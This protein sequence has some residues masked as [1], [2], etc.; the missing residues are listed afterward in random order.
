MTSL[1][2]QPSS[3]VFNP[4]IFLSQDRTGRST[5]NYQKNEKIFVQG[6]PAGTVCYIRKGRVKVT[7]LS[8]LGKEAVIGFPARGRFFG[9]GCL[10][11]AELRISTAHAVEECPVTSIVKAT[12]IATLDAEPKFSA[13]FV[14]FLLSQL[15]RKN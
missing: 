6:E 4:R 10:D 9:E 14:A 13:F 8:D 15:Q 3:S 12:T 2:D 1:H 5:G 11:G 7:V